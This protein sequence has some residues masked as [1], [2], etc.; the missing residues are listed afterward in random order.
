[1]GEEG[2]ARE[3]GGQ[4]HTLLF[5]TGR[6]KRNSTKKLKRNT[7]STYRNNKIEKKG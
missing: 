7:N 4:S 1:L 5:K 6:N 3:T 2:V